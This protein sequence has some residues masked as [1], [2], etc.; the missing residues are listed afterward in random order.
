V[1]Y[2]VSDIVWKHSAARGAAKF[3]L[4]ALA[5]FADDYGRCWPSLTTLVAR[6]RHDRRTVQRSIRQLEALGELAVA[7]GRGRGGVSH[8]TITVRD[9]ADRI[10]AV[11][12]VNEL[13]EKAAER[14]LLA[15]RKGGADANK[16]RRERPEKAA[17][18]P[19]K[20]AER[21]PE[22]VINPSTLRTG[23]RNGQFTTP[24][25]SASGGER[26]QRRRRRDD[27]AVQDD[28][29]PAEPLA[30]LAPEDRRVWDVARAD[31]AAQLNAPNFAQLVAPLEPI[32]RAPD[33]GLRL[34]APL[35]TPFD[36]VRHAVARALLD[37][38]DTAAR[39]VGIVEEGGE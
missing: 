4:L 14:R 3:V 5:S 25:P 19:E 26:A 24:G 36:R 7:S 20:A 34:R 33:G 16:R 1:S 28:A 17:D 2:R 15:S 32:G 37:A 35:G 12:A 29:A 38:G 30:P 11:A 18:L 23:Q 8:Y 22:P 10:A 27:V 6:T 39:H 13:T 9:P 31:L 21:R